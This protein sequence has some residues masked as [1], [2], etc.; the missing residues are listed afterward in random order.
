MY[1][2]H[3]LESPL[4][5]LPCLLYRPI[6]GL[7]RLLCPLYRRESSLHRRSCPLCQA[8]PGLHRLPCPLYQV[9]IVAALA[10]M[11]VALGDPWPAPAAMPV[12]PGRDRRCTG[13]N[14]H[15]TGRQARCA[16][17]SL[18]CTG[19]Q[20]HCTSCH[21]SALGSAVAPPMLTLLIGTLIEQV[22]EDIHEH[23]GRGCASGGRAHRA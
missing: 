10:T 22:K 6:P 16:G 18:A 11:P 9:G 13:G 2:L 8:I 12:V 23:R 7:H 4:H 15:C 3:R 1:S 21:A 19:C 14:R 5:E 20:A 17:R